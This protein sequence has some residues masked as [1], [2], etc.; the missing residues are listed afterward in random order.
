MGEYPQNEEGFKAYKLGWRKSCLT[1]NMKATIL[2]IFLAAT[3]GLNLMAQNIERSAITSGAGEA[4]SVFGETIQFTIGQAYMTNTLTQ[5][6]SN[7]IT[8][9]FQQ[10]SSFNYA[11]LDV[12]VFAE[13][14]LNKIQAFPNPAINFTNVVVNLIDDDG[15]KVSLIDMWGQALNTQDY[16]VTQGK[17]QLKFTFGFVPAGVYSLKVIANKKVYTKKLLIAGIESTVSL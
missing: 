10:P 5:N 6:G 9:G 13:S 12:P 11:S 8:Q 4:T 15:A 16:S 3:L 14:D 17:H 2:T 7:F 1:L